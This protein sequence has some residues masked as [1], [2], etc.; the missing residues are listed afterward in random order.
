MSQEGVSVLTA[1]GDQLIWSTDFNNFKIVQS[2]TTSVTKAAS[3]RSGS[4]TV[5]HNLDFVPAHMSYADG[6]GTNVQLPYVFPEMFDA[7]AD[8]HGRIAITMYVESCDETE[9]KFVLATPEGTFFYNSQM[10]ATIRYYL[11][12]ETASST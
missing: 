2:G 1:T 7:S 3:S 10:T 11:L 5:T 12:Q 6:P 9:I 4:A 8:G